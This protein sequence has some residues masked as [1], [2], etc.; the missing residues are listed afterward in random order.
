VLRLA[1][2]AAVVLGLALAVP[3]A[4]QIGSGKI[5][6]TTGSLG[7]PR[8][9]D[10][11]YTVNVD[12][13]HRTLL[14]SGNGFFSPR[15]SPDGSRVAF[16]DFYWE[17]SWPRYRLLVMDADG[18]NERLVAAG[19]GSIALSRQPW[20]PDGSRIA[21][22]GAVLVGNDTHTD[23]Y[24]ADADGGDVRQLTFDGASKDPPSWSPTGSTLVYSR[25]FVG[26][27]HWDLF[28]VVADGSGST[29]ITSSG[30][31]T[32]NRNP[33][34]APSGDWV[35]F[36]R[37]SDGV[38]GISVIHPDG[39]GLHR[40]C[41]CGAFEV[42]WSPDGTKIAYSIITQTGRYS[43][44][45]E[46]YAVGADGLNLKRLTESS[47]DTSPIWSPDGDRI[48]FMRGSRLTTMNSDGTCQVEVNEDDA[49]YEPVGPPG[50]SWQPVP[51]GPSVGQAHCNAI[52]VDAEA[53]TNKPAA[54][55]INTAVVNEGTEPLTQ[56]TL[57]ATAPTNLSP[58]I[59]GLQEQ[60]CSIRQ[61]EVTCRLSRLESG[62]RHSFSLRLDARR[63]ALRPRGDKAALRIGLNASASEQLLPTGR[64][65]DE[66]EFAITRCTNR[67]RGAGRI[68][69]T[70]FADKICGRRGADR[71]FPR[72]GSD[73]VNAGDGSD[74]INTV[75]GRRYRDLIS[76]GR[77]RDRVIADRRD[78]VLR[79]CERVERR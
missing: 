65:S 51:G 49:R 1:P 48:L 25:S 70:P 52:S 63:L 21:W 53:A 62:A 36:W 60:G 22:G 15:W 34:W 66:L 16:T 72:S 33:T 41:A 43:Y 13:S 40:V 55:L 46:L 12:G 59:A 42:T 28:V 75:D 50:Q 29:Q 56:V 57:V 7:N 78:R 68:D 71:I 17:G 64:E 54:V 27:E 19:T 5:A 79:N 32:Q 76:C 44:K 23:L 39:T 77:G 74:V 37:V 24:T 26:E 10:G 9:G 4:A 2:L 67:D 69:G 45:A 47:F 8:E 31:G 3:S 35:A 30:W 20:A 58:A 61:Q 6:Y 11:L 73:V 18:R 38:P 14:K